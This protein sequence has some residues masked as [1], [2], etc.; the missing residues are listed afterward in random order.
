MD[1]KIDGIS[2]GFPTSSPYTDTLNCGYYN[3]DEATYGI[4]GTYKCGLMYSQKACAYIHNN[5]STLCP[6]WHLPTT[7]EFKSLLRTCYI[8]Y[9]SL[10]NIAS[11]SKDWCPQWTGEDLFG[12]N[13]LPVGNYNHNNGFINF[14]QGTRLAGNNGY[15]NLYVNIPNKTVEYTNDSATNILASYIRLVKDY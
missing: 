12:F 10:I 4:D 6:G 5:R 13:L 9:K 8:P 3:N 15:S 11:L 1:W 14:G 7:D 2:L